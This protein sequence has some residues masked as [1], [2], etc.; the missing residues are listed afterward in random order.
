MAGHSNPWLGEKHCFK[1]VTHHQ[2][3]EANS[4]TRRRTHTQA[5]RE[6][7]PPLSGW[8]AGAA[9]PRCRPPPQKRRP[10]PSRCT[11]PD[12]RLSSY[13]RRAR[14]EGGRAAPSAGCPHAAGQAPQQSPPLLVEIPALAT[15]A[16]ACRQQREIIKRPSRE[17]PLTHR[18][19]E[20]LAG[21]PRQAG[22]RLR[23][24][25]P[26]QRLG[27]Q[28]HQRVLPHPLHALAAVGHRMGKEEEEGARDAQRGGGRRGSW[29]L[30]QGALQRNDSSDA[31]SLG[32][33]Q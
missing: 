10:P 21:D 7:G 19:Q 14:G 23:R 32:A 1:Q 22:A 3:R 26:Q 5:K 27:G 16:A 20:I 9:R 33:V 28:P 2:Q 13:G 11:G 30:I 18:G 25:P 15:Q 6:R 24:L 29:G 4:H 31:W 17:T 12:S 8:P